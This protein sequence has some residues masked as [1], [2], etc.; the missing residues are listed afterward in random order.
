[1]ILENNKAKNKSALII[2]SAELN[3]SNNIVNEQKTSS[4]RGLLERSGLAFKVVEGAYNTYREVSFV[5]EV[6]N[7]DEVKLIRDFSLLF[8]QESFLH[9]DENRK[10]RLVFNGGKGF[11]VVGKFQAVP[12]SEALASN[13]FTYC[14][15]MNEYF[16]CK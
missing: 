4:L 13:S 1:M 12:M 3:T 15:E 6:K 14:A 5:V 7:I 9:L 16:I 8:K 2:L 11:E 10:A